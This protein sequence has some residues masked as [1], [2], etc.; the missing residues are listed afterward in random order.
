MN[1]RDR[2]AH[3]SGMRRRRRSWRIRASTAKTFDQLAELFAG[4]L[5]A[6]HEPVPERKTQRESKR[7]EF[8][9]KVSK[10]ERENGELLSYYQKEIAEKAPAAAI[11]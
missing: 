6:E 5:S 4:G 11:V 10:V 3:H 7:D 8:P 9:K 2:I 1:Q